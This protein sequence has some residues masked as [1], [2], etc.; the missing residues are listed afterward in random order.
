MDRL[1]NHET[2]EHHRDAFADSPNVTKRLFYLNNE[3]PQRIG[4]LRT[5][6]PD[7]AL[8][9]QKTALSDLRERNRSNPAIPHAFL[10]K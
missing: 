6:S 2:R 9:A 10:P 1:N 7:P 3:W 5:F 4:D 8:R